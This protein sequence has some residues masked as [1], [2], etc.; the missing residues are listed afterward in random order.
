M[1]DPADDEA[2]TASTEQVPGGA[3]PSRVV[4]PDQLTTESDPAVGRA[5]VA[6]ASGEGQAVVVTADDG[7]YHALKWH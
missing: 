7:G 1:S 6:F 2:H 3:I 4:D 5:S